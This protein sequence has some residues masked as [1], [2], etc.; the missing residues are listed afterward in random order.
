MGEPIEILHEDFDCIVLNKPSGLLTQSPPGIDSLEVL[1]RGYIG[2]KSGRAQHVYVGVPHRLDRPAS[3]AIVMGLSRKSTQR[4]AKQFERREVVKTYWALVEGRV[5]VDEGTWRDTMRKVP[6]RALAELITADHPDAQSASLSYRVLARTSAA[7]WLEI[8]LQTGRT[9]Q[10]RLQAAARG[11]PILGD[12]TYGGQ[13]PF[14]P[15]ITDER[16]RPI[17]LHARVL[18][19]RQPKTRES[20]ELL[21]PVSSLWRST[22]FAWET[23]YHES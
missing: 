8:E 14:G 12:I 18:G 1:V 15:P 11:Y 23:P 17:A 9:H 19:F 20:I 2:R 16:H 10:I 7:T 4:L 6:G 5:P 21:A 3:G 22:E 13:Q